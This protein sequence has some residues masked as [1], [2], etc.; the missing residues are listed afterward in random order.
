MVRKSAVMAAELHSSIPSVAT[1][2]LRL[3]VGLNEKDPG[4]FGVHHLPAWF[5]IPLAP[6]L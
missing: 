2:R 6:V 5:T 3:N 4:K 1:C